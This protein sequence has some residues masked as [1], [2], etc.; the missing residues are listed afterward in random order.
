MITAETSREGRLLTL[1]YSGDVSAE[2]L[3]RSLEK[4]RE[5]LKRM[6]P[7]FTLLTDLSGLRKME[8]GCATALG[9]LMELC[10]REGLAS[11]VRVIP[12]PQR[13]IGFVLISRFHQLRRVR[14]QTYETM[15]AALQELEL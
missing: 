13:D 9:A 7:G 2:E 3:R 1:R 6:A 8:A 15:D 12:D 14:V 10:D 4:V 11:S 5:H